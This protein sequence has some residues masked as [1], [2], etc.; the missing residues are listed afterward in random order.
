MTRVTQ[1][2]HD[3]GKYLL[4]SVYPLP[5]HPTH[6]FTHNNCGNLETLPGWPKKLQHNRPARSAGQWYHYSACHDWWTCEANITLLHQEPIS[7]LWHQCMAFTLL[8]RKIP[9]SVQPTIQY[10]K[11][12]PNVGDFYIIKVWSFVIRKCWCDC[13]IYI[14]M[15]S[16]AIDDESSV[17]LTLYVLNFWR[18]HKIFTFHVIP[19][20]WYDTSSW[21]Y[22]SRK[23]G[24]Y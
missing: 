19:S 24:T 5:T 20:H 9:Y 21:N 10:C 2:I 13:T 3:A 23:T 18:K 15:P 12:S 6:N 7:F 17:I 4:I 22:S 16:D 11:V 8:Q 1:L 14:F